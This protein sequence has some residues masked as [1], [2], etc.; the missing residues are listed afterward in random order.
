MH[1]LNAFENKKITN[2]LKKNSSTTNLQHSLQIFT[3]EKAKLQTSYDARSLFVIQTFNIL[4]I[5]GFSSE[6][7]S[8]KLLVGINCELTNV[9]AL[10]KQ[11]IFV[12][13]V[14]L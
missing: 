10:S 9:T 2:D 6:M 12:R 14:F 7:N 8:C 1:S 13:K 11:R 5:E 3:N 4:L